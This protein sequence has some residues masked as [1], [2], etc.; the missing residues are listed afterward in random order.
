LATPSFVVFGLA[1]E[2]KILLVMELVD[3]F[4]LTFPGAVRNESVAW[5][6]KSLHASALVNQQRRVAHLK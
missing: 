2:Q 1:T 5:S 6:K 4:T 3:A